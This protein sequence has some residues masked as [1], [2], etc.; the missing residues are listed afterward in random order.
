MALTNIYIAANEEEAMHASPKTAMQDK[1]LF[2]TNLAGLL[3]QTR[4]GIIDLALSEDGNTVMILFE[5]G[6]TRR[7]NISCDSYIAIVRDVLKA[8]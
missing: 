4:E 2:I 3:R 6:G 7:V 5:G 8:I 1:A